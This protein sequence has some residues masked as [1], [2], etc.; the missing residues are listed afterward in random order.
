MIKMFLV[1]VVVF[2]LF[3]FGIPAFRSLTK[4]E[5]L[6]LTKLVGYSIMCAV[7]AVMLLS[8]LVI[9]F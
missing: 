7:F 2:L 4:T 5:K 1:F 3:F 9:L 6:D 8:I